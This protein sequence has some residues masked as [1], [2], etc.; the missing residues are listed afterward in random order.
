M[1][2]QQ[3]KS[4]QKTT[5]QLFGEE[6]VLK[7]DK[8]K[9][10]IHNYTWMEGVMQ[11]YAWWSCAPQ[12]HRQTC[13]GASTMGKLRPPE[14]I[15]KKINQLL[16]ENETKIAITTFGVKKK[17]RTH[18]S[19]TFFP[20]A[21]RGCRRSGLRA[22]RRRGDPAELGCNFFIINKYLLNATVFASLGKKKGQDEV[23]EKSMMDEK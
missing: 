3:C 17:T 22:R 6:K 14:N 7:T 11:N 13:R 15:V 21:E 10:H 4:Q 1:R 8:F 16:R 5:S 20:S 18:K 2:G 19:W 23:Q 12:V 9:D